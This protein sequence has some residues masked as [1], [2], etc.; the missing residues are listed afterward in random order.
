MQ[1]DE[2]G[3][4]ELSAEENQALMDSLDIPESQ[5]DD[6]PVSIE[7][8]GMEDNVARFRVINTET[9]KSRT[10]EFDRMEAG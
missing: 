3:N 5:Y 2:E 4:L 8:L 7:Y 6:P 1:I 10:M 9:Q